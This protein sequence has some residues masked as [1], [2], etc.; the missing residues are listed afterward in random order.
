MSIKIME[1]IHQLTNLLTYLN[2]Q[3]S[4]VN[5]DYDSL[6]IKIFLKEQIDKIGKIA[7]FK[8]IE[9]VKMSPSIIE[10]QTDEEDLYG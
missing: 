6:I 9:L 1:E 10:K 5:D 4:E 3:L 2:K 8:L 7:S